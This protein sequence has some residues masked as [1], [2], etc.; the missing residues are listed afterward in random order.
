[1]F[2]LSLVLFGFC[3]CSMWVQVWF[4][5]WFYFG[6]D[7]W[8]VCVIHWGFILG[9]ICIR[10]GFY[11]GFIFGYYWGVPFSVYFGFYSDFE[12]CV[13]CSF[14]VGSLLLRFGFDLGFM[15]GF[16][17][18]LFGLRLGCCLAFVWLV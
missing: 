17:L 11:L 3:L 15:S 1:M 13:L 7:G 2:G 6:L 12:F 10:F 9:F 4:L 16:I 18:V 8:V 14:L 5:F